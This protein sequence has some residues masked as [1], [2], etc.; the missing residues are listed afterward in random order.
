[1]PLGTEIGLDAGHIVLD[2]D[3]APLALPPPKKGDTASPP[4]SSRCLLCQTAGWIKVPLGNEVYL[5]PC[6]IVLD[7]D[8]YPPPRKG[9]QQPPTFGPMST[10]AKRS[11]I[12]ATDELLLLIRH[13]RESFLYYRDSEITRG[14]LFTCGARRLR[15]IH[16]VARP[17]RRRRRREIVT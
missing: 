5:G 16:E 4:N 9:A 1:M 17:L 7:G 10:V 8:P 13:A 6:H 14:H 12:S 11:P 2:G 3:P 15:M